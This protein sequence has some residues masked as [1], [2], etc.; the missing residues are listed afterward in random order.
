MRTFPLLFFCL[1]LAAFAVRAD[2]PTD[3][4]GQWVASDKKSDSADE[5]GSNAPSPSGAHSGGHGGMGGHGGRGGGRHGHSPSDTATGSSAGAQNAQI[6]PRAHAH[7]LVIR[8]SDTVFDIAANGQRTAYRFDNRNNY[9]A[10]YGGTVTLTWEAPELVIETHPDNGGTFA[11]Y[12]TLSDDNKTLTLRIVTQTAGS[13]EEKETR[14]VFVRA[15]DDA[16]ASAQ[17]LP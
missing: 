1:A 16:A 15:G 9:G 14:R 3:F 6:D 4:S 7:S 17:T 12:Y 8:Q 2:E 11:E 13:D 10:A 5:S